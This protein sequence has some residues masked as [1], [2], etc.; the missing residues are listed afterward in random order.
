MLFDHNDRVV[1]VPP[2]TFV[3]WWNLWLGTLLKF[4]NKG[5]EGVTLFVTLHPLLAAAW[6]PLGSQHFHT[7]EKLKQRKFIIFAYWTKYFLSKI[8]RVYLVYIT[9]RVEHSL[10][11]SVY[12][13]PEIKYLVNQIIYPFRPKNI[14]IWISEFLQCKVGE[15]DTVI[16]KTCMYE[17]SNESTGNWLVDVYS[18]QSHKFSNCALTL[19]CLYRTVQEWSYGKRGGL[20]CLTCASSTTEVSPVLS[21]PVSLVLH[22]LKQ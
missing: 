1:E 7:E 9:Y 14:Q 18:N 16:I 12:S 2:P 3:S 5:K 4:S 20:C 8:R 17:N 19:W 22:W 21:A 6:N 11:Y 10:Y 13:I 15:F